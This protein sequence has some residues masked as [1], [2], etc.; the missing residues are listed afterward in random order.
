MP[1]YEY[2][3]QNCGHVYEEFVRFGNEPELTC[4]E[5][6]GADARKVVSLLGNAGAAAGSDGATSSAT[7]C[8]PTGG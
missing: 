6:G 8:A 1:I 7:A 3:C 2:R 5:C 4:P